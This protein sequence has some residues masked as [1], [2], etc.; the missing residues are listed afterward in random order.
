LFFRR[1]EWLGSASGDNLLRN[2]LRGV[3]KE[4]LRVT[5]A[6][7]LSQRPHPRA[8]GS[9]LMH[10]SITTDYSEALL[11]LVTPPVEHNWQTLQQLYDIHAF[12]HRKLDGELLWPMSMP[13]ALAGDE[14][15]PIANYGTSN[16]G[17]V[18]TIYRRGL[19]HRYGRSMQAIAGVHFNYSPPA[20]FWDVWHE[21]EG[22]TGS[23]S[24]F[25]SD[26]LM[27]L[28]RNYRRHAWLVIYLFGASPAFSRS[29]LPAGNA[30]VEALDS[31]TWYAPHATSLRMSDIGYQ[32]KSQARLQISANSIAEYVSGLV[33]A[34]T[35]VEPRY[36]D[37]GVRV[38]GDYRQLNANVLQI[39]NEF[40]ST[41]RPKPSKRAARTTIGLREHGVEYVEVRTL[42]LSPAD[43]VGMN[44]SQLRFLETLLLHCLL[45]DSPPIEDGELEEIN[46]RSLLVARSGRR[47]GLEL[48][49]G[50]RMLGLRAAAAPLR[51]GMLEIAARL[52][53]DGHAYRD[54]VASQWAAIENPA[55]TPSARLLAAMRSAGSSFEEYAL[56]VARRHHDYFMSAPLEPATMTELE[57]LAEASLRA[58]AEREA[59]DT[60][61]FDQYLAEFLTRV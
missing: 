32:N 49:F 50:E 46:A 17:M 8:L 38:G 4:T 45:S 35:T 61:G 29:F 10:P 60:L 33:A 40:Y 44:Q 2:G 21:A 48:P 30:L 14:A 52:D 13:C 54:S 6:G 39:E 34:I 56:D 47:P 36:A 59:T 26:R 3:E 28:V 41:I 43:P 27:G 24:G 42:D 51:D 20:A 23:A 53:R 57:Q 15:I 37:I 5:D 19:G 1:L 11:E 9:A 25:K 16:A 22:G 18:R 7:A 12:I 31:A 55:L 58:Q